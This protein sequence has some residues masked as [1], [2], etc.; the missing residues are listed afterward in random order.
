MLSDDKLLT[1]HN[2]TAMIKLT[3]RK[4]ITLTLMV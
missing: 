2:T 1:G 4:N 3:L